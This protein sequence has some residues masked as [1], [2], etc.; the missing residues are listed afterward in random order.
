MSK[1]VKESIKFVERY[2]FPLGLPFIRVL[3]KREDRKTLLD[4]ARKARKILFVKLGRVGEA[5]LT[6]PVLREANKNGIK[7]DVLCTN[8]SEKVYRNQRF[9]SKVWVW[10]YNPLGLLPIFLKL[11]KQSYDF[12]VDGEPFSTASAIYAYFISR[13]VGFKG[14]RRD[15]LYDIKIRYNDKKHVTL[16]Y[17]DLFS[18]FLV[19]AP[20]KVKLV[21]IQYS[22]KDKQHAKNL[23]RKFRMKKKVVF[24]LSSGEAAPMRRWPLE[25]WLSLY[26]KMRGEYGDKFVLFLV[27]RKEDSKLNEKFISGLSKQE[28]AGVVD[29]SGKTSILG[30]TAFLSFVD[31]LISNDSGTVHVASSVNTPTIGLYG[32]E[33]PVRFGPLSKKNIAIYKAG[34]LPCAPCINVHKGQIPKVCPICKGKAIKLITV[35]DV[36]KA[37]KKML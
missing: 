25:R 24:S 23:V 22:K 37:V 19:K 12:V 2:F 11:R 3:K 28:K 10:D 27:G 14:L 29:L 16:V 30:L 15:V 20:K 31:L 17:F 4:N 33:T 9:I 18:P 21:S 7:I 6:L 32:P 34:K 13:T 35:E 5:I 36:F 26:R 1:V 8:Y